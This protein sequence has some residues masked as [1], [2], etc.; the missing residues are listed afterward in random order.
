MI[1]SKTFKDELP[2]REKFHSL[3]RGKETNNKE[4]IHVLKVWNKFGMKTIIDYR[5]LYLRCNVLLLVDVFEKVRNNSIKNYAFISKSLF[6]ST[7][8]KMGCNT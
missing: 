2:T 1:E 4:Y 7:S 8:V 6:K 3:L 5:D